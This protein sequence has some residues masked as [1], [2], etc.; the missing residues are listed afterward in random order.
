M[1]LN[2]LF[3]IDERY[4]DILIEKG[5]LQFLEQFIKNNTTNETIVIDHHAKWRIIFAN[6]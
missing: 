1:F 4:V 6:N 2:Q 5:A 3:S